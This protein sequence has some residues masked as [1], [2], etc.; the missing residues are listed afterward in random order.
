MVNDEIERLLGGEP[1]Q[2]SH[3]DLYKNIV[4]GWFYIL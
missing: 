1:D 3:D 4:S 2:D